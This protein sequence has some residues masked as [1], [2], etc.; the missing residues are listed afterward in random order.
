MMGKAAVLGVLLRGALTHKENVFD[1]NTQGVIR[2]GFE[3]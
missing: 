3:T 2:G 1:G